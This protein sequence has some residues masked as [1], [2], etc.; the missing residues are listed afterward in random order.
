MPLLQVLITDEQ[1][2]MLAAM[3]RRLRTSKAKLIREGVE[4]VLRHRQARTRDS[5][6]E[7]VGQA[8]RVRRKDISRRQDAYPLGVDRKRT[9]RGDGGDTERT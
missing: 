6:L 2:R 7:L 4:L 3:A 1:N 8:G 5:L 9:R